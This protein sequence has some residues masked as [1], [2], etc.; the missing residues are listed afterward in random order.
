MTPQDII[1]ALL[2][3]DEDFFLD[4]SD[5]KLLLKDIKCVIDYSEGKDDLIESLLM[6][7]EEYNPS[8]KEYKDEFGRSLSSLFPLGKTKKTLSSL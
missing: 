8:F 4:S 5:K 1:K 3:Y 6:V 2:Q 7:L